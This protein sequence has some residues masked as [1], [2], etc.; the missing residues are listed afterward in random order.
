MGEGSRTGCHMQCQGKRR[1]SLRVCIC[2]WFVVRLV[3]MT[4]ERE[5]GSELPSGAF[6]ASSVRPGRIEGME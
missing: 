1:Q 5:A 4:L 3:H 2:E 6:G